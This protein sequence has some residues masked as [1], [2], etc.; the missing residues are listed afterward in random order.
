MPIIDAQVH[1]YQANTPAR[2]WVG[3]LAGP[4]HV[5]GEEMVAAMDS[6]GVHG[7]LLVSPYSLYRFDPSYALQVYAAHPG[8][9]A[10][11][12]PVNTQDPAV[13]GTI[14]D[15]AAT[16]GTVA[17][18][19]MFNQDVPADPADPGINRALTAART[20]N[21]PV[22]MLCWGRLVQVVG[23]AQR[24]PDTIMVIDHLGLQQP[25][26]PP[27]PPDPWADLPKV[28]ALAAYP[29]IRIKITG[30]CTLSHKPFPYDDIW[31]SVCR[32]IDT[33]GLDRCL[34]GTDWTRATA[35]LTYKQGVDAF[36]LSERF[37]DSDRAT[38]MGGAL[39]RVYRWSPQL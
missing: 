18:R 2:P 32:I 30:A 6:V 15:W 7:A 38:L 25:F 1:A 37:S 33:F 16:K 34:W 11:I 19:I 21:L 35:L 8:R 31:D 3:H 23:L 20:N 39:E 10:L 22:N 4:P 17:I 26:E 24:N 12:K 28:L 5:T 36:L 9:F 27:A 29:N 13:A 14:A